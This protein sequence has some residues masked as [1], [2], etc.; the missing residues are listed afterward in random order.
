MKL[1]DTFALIEIDRGDVERAERLDDEGKH[2]LNQVTVTEMFTGVEYK[3]E[4]NTEE[5]REAKEKLDRL[6]SR[7]KIIQIDRSISIEAAKI[8]ADLKK[9]GEP[10]DDLHDVYI[11]ATGVKRDLEILTK[12]PG[13][14]RNIEGLEVREWEEY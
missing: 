11:A 13:H 9:I 3:Y 6:L 2:A 1:L 12:N 14:F 4:R 7:F 5:Y 10:V 8:I